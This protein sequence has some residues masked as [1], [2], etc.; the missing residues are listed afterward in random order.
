MLTIIIAPG[1]GAQLL[2][3][4][5]AHLGRILCILT[6]CKF[7]S[8]YE[9]MYARCRRLRCSVIGVAIS[10]VDSDL[11]YGCRTIRFHMMMRDVLSPYI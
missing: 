3:L 7:S 5:I 4:P 11:A 6:M 8:H 2:V 10:R 1:P 9:T